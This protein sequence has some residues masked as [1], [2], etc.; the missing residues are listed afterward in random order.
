MHRYPLTLT[1]LVA[2]VGVIAALVPYLTQSFS[3]ATFAVCFIAACGMLAVAVHLLTYRVA[4]KSDRICIQT[5]FATKEIAS[6]EIREVGVVKTRNGPQ[7]VVSLKNDKVLRFGRML[8][9]FSA[10]LDALVSKPGAGGFAS[11]DGS[12]S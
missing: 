6:S 9:N 7:I 12:V 1:L 4:V 2:A 8:T 3:T 10:M 11:H 5:A